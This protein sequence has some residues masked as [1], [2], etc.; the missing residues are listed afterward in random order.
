MKAAREGKGWCVVNW[1]ALWGKVNT[2][3]RLTGVDFIRAHFSFILVHTRTSTVTHTCS[4]RYVVT[5]TTD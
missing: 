3:I 5:R 1:A 2:A 4:Y